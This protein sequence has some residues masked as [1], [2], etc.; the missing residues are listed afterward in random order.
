MARIV[1]GICS[2]V[3]VVGAITSLRVP[4]NLQT[5]SKTARQERPFFHT[6][7]LYTVLL[8]GLKLDVF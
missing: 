7:P 6:R 8:S 3:V 4:M 2:G 1:W 5:V